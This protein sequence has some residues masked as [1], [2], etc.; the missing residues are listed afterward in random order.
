M[1]KTSHVPK[2]FVVD[3]D[4]P[5]EQRWAEIGAAYASE[6]W[7][8]INYLR[9]NLP[10]GWL[11]PLEKLSSHLLPFFHDY[12]DEMHGYAQAL[13]IS[14][15]DIVM[16]NLVYQLERLG[17]D[18]TSWNTTGP[19]ND[20]ICEFNPPPDAVETEET[21]NRRNKRK[22]IWRLRIV[23]AV[24]ARAAGQRYPWSMYLICC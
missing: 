10:K 20:K 14:D 6:S 22:Q 11:K 1:G 23:P 18:C 9:V 24:G 13:N 2:D 17:I 21:R 3:L 16:V 8:I 15:G 19:T 4:L 7:Q 5:A 12:G